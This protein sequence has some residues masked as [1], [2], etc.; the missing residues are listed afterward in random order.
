MISILFFYFALPM[1]LAAIVIKM[2]RKYSPYI[3][4]EDIQACLAEKP[5]PKKWFRT[6][7][8]DHKGLRTLGDFETHTEAVDCAYKGKEIST[9]EGEKVAFLILNQKGE[10]FEEVN[11]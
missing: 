9:Q 6:V 1:T 5:L 8:R 2:I 4:A 3:P 11:S 10:V 7:R